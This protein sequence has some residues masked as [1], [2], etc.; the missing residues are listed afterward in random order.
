MPDERT[1]ISEISRVTAEGGTVVV[2]A[3]VE[4]GPPILI[5]EGYRFIDRKRRLTESPSE[6]WNEFLGTSLS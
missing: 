2:S 1:A 3:P 4:V 5:R 6:L